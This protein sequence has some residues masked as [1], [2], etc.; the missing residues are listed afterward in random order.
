MSD[1]TPR[2]DETLPALGR[3]LT[4]VDRP[5]SGT[6]I[7]KALGVLCAA[8][9]LIDFFIVK[10]GHF[11]IEDIPGFYGVYG[12]VCFVCVIYGAKTLRFFARR[13]EDYYGRQAIDREEY[14]RDQ[15]G[16]DE[17]ANDA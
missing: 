6:T 3:M 10:H 1:R 8:L 15:T 2:T 12:F 4:W 11:H 7:F 9:F 13:D 17:E 16:A 14:P 5:G